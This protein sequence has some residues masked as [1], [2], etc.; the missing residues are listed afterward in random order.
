MV[1]FTTCETCEE[2]QLACTDFLAQF[3]NALPK[4]MRVSLQ[5]I[6]VA[7]IFLSKKKYIARDTRGDLVS[8]GTPNVRSDWPAILKSAYTET[9]CGLLDCVGDDELQSLAKRQVDHIRGSAKVSDFI[10]YR[11]I[12]DPNSSSRH[13]ELAR[14]ESFRDDGARYDNGDAIEYVL[15]TQQVCEG[16][17]PIVRWALPE[18]LPPSAKLA[19]SEYARMFLDQLEPLLSAALGKERAARCMSLAKQD[20]VVRPSLRTAFH[21]VDF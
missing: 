10:A 13:A 15:Y 14:T 3:N 2:T 12:A 21:D 19:V 7:C 8:I 6:F 16:E 18:H 11:R 1:T 9:A 17:K 20:R 5:G 4:P